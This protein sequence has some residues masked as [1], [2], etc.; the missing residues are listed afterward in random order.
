[1]DSIRELD[2]N[3]THV[4]VRLEAEDSLAVRLISLRASGS[5]APGP[6]RQALERQAHVVVEQ[7][8]YL[9]GDL[10]VIEVDAVSNAVQ[11]RSKKPEAGRFVEVVLREGNLLTLEGRGASIHLSKEDYERLI[12]TVSGLFQ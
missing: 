2:A 7:I 3:G 8:T 5:P 12:A 11:I 6:V 4:T 1:M 9:G 10:A